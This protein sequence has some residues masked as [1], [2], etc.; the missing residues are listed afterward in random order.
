MMEYLRDGFNRLDFFIVV[1]VDLE[2]PISPY[3]F[4]V[5]VDLEYAISPNNMRTNKFT[6][7]LAAIL[8]AR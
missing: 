4:R 3:N 8:H 6:C 2:Y 7:C 5:F 1:F